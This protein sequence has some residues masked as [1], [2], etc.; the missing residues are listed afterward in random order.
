M[1]KKAHHLPRGVVDVHWAVQNQQIRIQDRLL[2]RFQFPVVGTFAQLRLKAGVAAPAG[3]TKV[4]GQEKLLC[5]TADL[6]CQLP[7][8]HTGAALVVLPV[9]HDNLHP[10]RPFLFV[11]PL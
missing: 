8:D 7:G 4:P 9:D 2:Q 6:F 1:V 11:T 3:L 10:I 5:F